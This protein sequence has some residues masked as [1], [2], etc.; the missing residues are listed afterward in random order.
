MNDSQREDAQPIQPSG[1]TPPP[2]LADDQFY[3][4]LAATH[5]RRLLYHLL[6]ETEGTVA[7]IA[8][9]LGGWE[10]T[11][12]GT[13]HT[14]TDRAKLRV[15]LEH[16]HLPRLDDAGLIDYDPQ[17]DSVRIESLHPQVAD[18]VRRSVEAEGPERS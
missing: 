18:I 14:P 2:R 12:G 1:V 13:M 4:A 11:T 15:Q 16:N 8:T 7:E 10:A 9:V 3:R 6:D 5:R 17:S